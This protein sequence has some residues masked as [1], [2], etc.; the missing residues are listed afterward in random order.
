MIWQD[1]EIIIVQ[2]D[3]TYVTA[4][5]YIAFLYLSLIT[6]SERKVRK[7]ISLCLN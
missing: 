6:F 7:I 5:R 3:I 1:K 2:F 4:V